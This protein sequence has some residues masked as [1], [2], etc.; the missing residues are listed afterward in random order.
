VIAGEKAVAKAVPHTGFASVDGLTT[1]DKG[2]HFDARSQIDLGKRFASEMARL[3]EKA[4][5]PA[6]HR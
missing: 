1:G 6:A 4:G 2:T 5:E 3:L